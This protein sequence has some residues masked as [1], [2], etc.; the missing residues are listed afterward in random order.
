LLVQLYQFHPLGAPLVGSAGP[1]L[2]VA[3]TAVVLI[4]VLRNL[5]LTGLPIVAAGAASNLAA[6]T[7]NGGYIHWTAQRI[8]SFWLIPHSGP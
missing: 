2:Y 5:R 4:V 3:T 1:A 7:A 8:P 6:I